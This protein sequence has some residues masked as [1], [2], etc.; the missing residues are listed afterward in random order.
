M[1]T[2]SLRAAHISGIWRVG[3]LLVRVRK[4]MMLMMALKLLMIMVNTCVCH[5]DGD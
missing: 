3:R 1:E 2:S 4:L 5:T